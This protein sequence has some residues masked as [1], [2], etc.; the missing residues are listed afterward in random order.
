MGAF[1]LWVAKRLGV[2]ALLSGFIVYS[3]VALIATGSIWYLKH[4]YDARVIAKYVAEQKA[5]GGELSAQQQKAFGN[6]LTEYIAG[7][8]EDEKI[9]PLVDYALDAVCVRE[10][11]PAGAGI[12]PSE[13]RVP[14]AGAGTADRRLLEVA[15]ETV[16]A[17]RALRR[18]HNALVLDATAAGARTD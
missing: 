12:S 4:A 13:R 7:V 18:R 17:C 15:K 11:A 14:E 6:N 2:T 5:A 8:R 10:P 9:A 3:W 16:R 1:I